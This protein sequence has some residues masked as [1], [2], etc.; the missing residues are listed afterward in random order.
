MARYRRRK[1]RR[2]GSPPSPEGPNGGGGIYGT[3]VGVVEYE[4][5]SDNVLRKK[6]S[7]NSGKRKK[8]KK[9]PQSVPNQAPINFPASVTQQNPTAGGLGNVAA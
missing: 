4:P 5:G 2:P 6:Y 3:L 7:D 9:L 8:D 1:H